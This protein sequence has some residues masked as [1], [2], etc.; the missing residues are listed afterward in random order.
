LSRKREVSTELVKYRCPSC[1]NYEEPYLHVNGFAFMLCSKCS[2]QFK[3]STKV[4]ANFRKFCSKT[5]RKPTR[6][7]TY[8]SSSERAVKTYL[9]R[10]GLREG[11]D[12]F[13]NSRVRVEKKGKRIYYWFDFVIPSKKLVI[14]VDPEIWH[15]LGD[16]ERSD[17]EKRKFVNGLG[18]KLI[19]LNTEA[20]RKLN[21]Q[22]K[23]SKTRPVVC[24]ELDKMFYPGKRVTVILRN[25]K[26]KS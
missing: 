11:L 22:R 20:V 25:R 3:T 7:P 13:H 19:S 15:R 2:T 21:R 16:R 26:K 10:A 14:E 8:Y 1:G 9:E 18:W 23:D 24:R 12:F 5:A 4:S 6:S 17:S